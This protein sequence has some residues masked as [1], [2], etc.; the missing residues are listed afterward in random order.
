MKKQIDISIIVPVYNV[1]KY[2]KRCLL[3]LVNQTIKNYE[4]LVIVDGSTDNS[5]NIINDIS[6]RNSNKIKVFETENKGWQQKNLGIKNRRSIWDS[7]IQT[8]M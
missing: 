5:I 8:I 1:E 4:I 7:S 3:S 2:I 6:K